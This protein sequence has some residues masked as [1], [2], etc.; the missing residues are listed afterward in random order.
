[1][2]MD[3][4]HGYGHAAGTLDIQQGHEHER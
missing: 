3:M 4:K 2:Y 1:M